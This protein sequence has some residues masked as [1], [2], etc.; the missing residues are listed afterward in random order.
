M[1]P[2]ILS[3]GCFSTVVIGALLWGYRR[4]RARGTTLKR[5][6]SEAKMELEYEKR[7]SSEREAMHTASKAEMKDSFRA[8]SADALEK[9][10]QQFLIL[11]NKSFEKLQSQSELKLG[12]HESDILKMLKPTKEALEKLDLGMKQIEKE[13]NEERVTLKEQLLKMVESEQRLVTETQNLTSALRRPDV[14]G[15]WGEMQ[16]RRV[17]EVSG[18]IGHCDFS[19]QV[20]LEGEDG[21]RR[22]DMVIHLPGNRSVVVDAKATFDAFLEANQM[23]DGE[24][25]RQ[26]LKDHAKRLK[27]HIQDLGK[28]AYFEH[29][30]QTPEFVILFLPSEIFFSA[31]LEID[32]TL[33]ELG[34]T[35]GVILATPTTL[36]GLLKAIAY[37]WK[38]DS[39]SQNARVISE[40]GHELSKRLSDMTRHWAHVGKSLSSSVDA[41]NKAMGSYERRVLVSARKF[42]E[43]TCLGDEI[44]L[45]RLE[46]IEKIPRDVDDSL[47]SPKIL[48]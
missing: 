21:R 22:P 35:L 10:S 5:E 24:K 40:M 39:L 15:R 32:P 38:Q 7:I 33:I 28:K 14:R 45:D 34:A 1:S 27:H 19:E 48:P 9:S 36:I 29:F 18:M 43:L 25:R 2:E 4:E 8:L 16:L 42:K 41:F 26:R 37:G 3:L 46:F 6:L 17:V 20:H 31:A 13:R 44:D 11:A 30:E 23:E 12:Q 47:A